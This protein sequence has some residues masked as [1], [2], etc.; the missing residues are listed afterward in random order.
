MQGHPYNPD[1]SAAPAFRHYGHGAPGDDPHALLSRQHSGG[2]S[3]G[4]SAVNGNGHHQDIDDI[5]AHA[6]PVVDADEVPE[7]ESALRLLDEHLRLHPCG[8]V[9]SRLLDRLL[10]KIA[11]RAQANLG[12]PVVKEPDQKEQDRPAR[13]TREPEYPLHSQLIEGRAN[14]E[15]QRNCAQSLK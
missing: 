11:Q 5:V 15:E 6:S 8:L 2:H 1:R 4:Q 3:Q 7:G 12:G 9:S 10:S 14:Q 13:Y